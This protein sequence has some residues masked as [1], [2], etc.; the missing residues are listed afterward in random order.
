MSPR[1]Y[2]SVANSICD[3]RLGAVIPLVLPAWFVP[4]ETITAE[5]ESAQDSQQ[6]DAWLSA[7]LTAEKISDM[8]LAQ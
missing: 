6:L 2:T 3:C 7:L 1:R 4:D 5:I 8:I